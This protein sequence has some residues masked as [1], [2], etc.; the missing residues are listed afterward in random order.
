MHNLAVMGFLSPAKCVRPSGTG[1]RDHRTGAGA[2]GKETAR[3]FV[4]MG[5][6]GEGVKPP[7][8]VASAGLHW[9]CGIALLCDSE[10]GLHTSERGAL[11]RM[12]ALVS[13]KPMIARGRAYFQSRYRQSLHRSN[14]GT[15]ALQPQRFSQAGRSSRSATGSTSTCTSPA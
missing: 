15:L 11:A 10:R 7:G 3:D 5:L 12:L 13:A 14:A 1:G 6:C 8:A 4:I 2:A 9:C